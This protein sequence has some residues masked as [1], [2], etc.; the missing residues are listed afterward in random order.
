MSRPNEV[1]LEDRIQIGM[2]EKIGHLAPG[3]R[4]RLILTRHDPLETVANLHKD[5][6][7]LFDGA[8]IHC[9]PD[10]DTGGL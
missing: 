3:L 7:I 8:A 10:L 4:S 2:A 6:T 5:K 9:P 1:P